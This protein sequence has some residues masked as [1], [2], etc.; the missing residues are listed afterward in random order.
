MAQLPLVLFKLTVFVW[1]HEVLLIRSPSH[2][3]LFAH[4]LVYLFRKRSVTKYAGYFGSYD[5]ERMPSVVERN[6]IQR[7]LG[8]PHYVMVYG[9][10]NKE[11]LI[12]FIPAVT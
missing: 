2:L 1:Q 4:L 9:K 10:H 3:G 6:F 5:E 7:F 12:S 8:P 11:H